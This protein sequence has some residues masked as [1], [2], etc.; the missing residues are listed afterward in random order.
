MQVGAVSDHVEVKD[1][2]PLLQT[3]QATVGTSVESRKLVEFR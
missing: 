3:E 1:S 2:A